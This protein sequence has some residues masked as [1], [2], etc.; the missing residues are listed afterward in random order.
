MLQP[1]R[2]R[3]AGEY[4]N[5][6]RC[7]EPR[8]GCRAARP[9]LEGSKSRSWLSGLPTRP[10]VRFP[11]Y[12]EA[13]MRS[14]IPLSRLLSILAVGLF[15]GACREP[16]APVGSSVGRAQVSLAP[17]DGLHGAIA[18]HSNRNGNVQI[19]VMNADGSHVTL[20]TNNTALNFGPVWSPDGTRIVFS[21]NVGGDFQIY[22]ID[23]DGTGMTQITNA[24]QAF[25]PVWSPDGRQIAFTS[26]RDGNFDVFV[27]NADGTGVT[28][29]NS[30]D[31]T[32]DDPVWSPDGKKIA[33]QS[34]RD[35]HEEIYIMNADGTGQ[36]RLTFNQGIFNAVPSWRSRPCH[37]VQ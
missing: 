10:V 28:Q 1:L 37:K 31:F 23:A 18:F 15:F 17:G 13:V 14:R 20:V 6:L 29:L 26:N 5:G 36:T 8:G 21:S 12:A 7:Y 35:G 32:D 30:G 16:A 34:T 33:F 27:M 24:A 11:S 25:N 3:N 22:V 2:G 19:F 4:W 9:C